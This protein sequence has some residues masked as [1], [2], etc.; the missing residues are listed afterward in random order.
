MKPKVLVTRRL[1]PKAMAL[2]EDHFEVTCNPHDRVLTREEILAEV[3][4]KDGLLPLLTDRVDGPLMD[5]AGD[6]LRIIANYAVGYNNIDLEA[7]TGR[8]IAVTNTPGVLTDTTADL[9]MA[10]LLGV[11]RRI[12]EAD[13]FLRAGR[14]ESWAPL[15]LL[16]ADVHG[17]TLGLIGFGRIGRAVAKR[18]A[19]FD[20]RILYHDHR[21][22]EAEVEQA[23]GAAYVEMDVLLRES[24]FVSVHVPLLPETRHLLGAGAFSRMKYEAFVINTSRGEVI[25][26]KALARALEEKRIA[27]A[28]LDV[29]EH[30]PQV[31]PEL[32][33]M[34]NVVL[35]PHIGSASVETRTKMGLIAAENLI[36]CFQ[37]RMPPNCLNPEVFP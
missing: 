23:Y 15:L 33:R 13:A 18:A 5:A 36:A 35:L 22:A 19:G 20:M 26:E 6:R 31:T 25:D 34:P 11:A 27:G 9:T 29:F 32:L 8:G 16:G 28:G 12:V 21:R 10:L 4:G 37:G 3:R 17:K 14:Y 24:D 30:E 2:L 1:P 7:A